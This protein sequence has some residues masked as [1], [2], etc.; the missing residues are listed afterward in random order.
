MISHCKTAQLNLGNS[1]YSCSSTTNIHDGV[2]LLMMRA[3]KK[4]EGNMWMELFI[5]EQ[6]YKFQEGTLKWKSQD[7]TKA[8]TMQASKKLIKRWPCQKF[9]D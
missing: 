4:Q 1:N 7:M 6:V 2:A 8:N 9:L 5:I 3:G